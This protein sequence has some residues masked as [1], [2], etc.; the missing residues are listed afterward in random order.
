MFF[1]EIWKNI[2]LV[3][4]ISK[5]RNLK[6]P[7]LE[8]WNLE[9]PEL[10][11]LFKGIPAFQ[12]W[13]LLVIYKDLVVMVIFFNVQHAVYTRLTSVWNLILSWNLVPD[14]RV[15]GRPTH[16]HDLKYD[17]PSVKLW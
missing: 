4:F 8:N 17:I 5:F 7:E 14:T 1:V 15:S 2:F 12:P 3:T 11:N 13:E 16:T 6:F 10:G 9:F